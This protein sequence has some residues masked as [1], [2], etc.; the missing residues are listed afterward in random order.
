M[1]PIKFLSDFHVL[2][3]EIWMT[4]RAGPYFKTRDPA[5]LA[6]LDKILL[7]GDVKPTPVI[8][9]NKSKFKKKA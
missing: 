9:A 6:V 7:I 3:A 8:A 4:E 1:Y 5:A 2:M